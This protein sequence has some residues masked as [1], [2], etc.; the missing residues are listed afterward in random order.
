M[1]GGPRAEKPWVVNLHIVDDIKFFCLNKK[2][3]K[4]RLL[5]GEAVSNSKHECDLIDRIIA[6]RADVEDAMVVRNIRDGDP[7]SDNKSVELANIQRGR[8]QA[9]QQLPDILEIEYPSFTYVNELGATVVRAAQLIRI[10]RSNDSKGSIPLIE[11]TPAMMVFVHEAGLDEARWVTASKRKGGHNENQTE[12]EP[13]RQRSF[14]L[15]ELSDD[16]PMK[17]RHYKNQRSALVIEYKTMD[18]KR[19]SK[20][21]TP[22]LIGDRDIDIEITKAVERTLLEVTTP[23]KE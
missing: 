23:Y 8:P 17:W 7:L 12:P 11:F 18:G 15:P 20:M 2:D 21:Q 19:A 9:V 10:L 1:E 13:T 14:V 16:S 5:I 6:L 22:K 3:R 4:M